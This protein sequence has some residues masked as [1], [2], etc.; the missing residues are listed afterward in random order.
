MYATIPWRR[1]QRARQLEVCRLN[2]P[3]SH[4][5]SSRRSAPLVL[6]GRLHTWL[7][8]CPEIKWSP[9]LFLAIRGPQFGIEGW[10]DSLGDRH[11]DAIRHAFRSDS[12]QFRMLFFTTFHLA[13]NDTLS[14]KR[15]RW[16]K[17]RTPTTVWCQPFM[18][19]N[20]YGLKSQFNFKEKMYFF[21]SCSIITLCSIITF[22]NKQGITQY[23]SR[24]IISL[25]SQR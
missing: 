10:G 18:K 25:V 22:D 9:R 19:G 21:P 7:A 15:G 4:S 6:H 12:G 13:I 17:M 14:R 3:P 8:W 24:N 20:D 16:L 23:I 1:Q 2:T 5:S 11:D